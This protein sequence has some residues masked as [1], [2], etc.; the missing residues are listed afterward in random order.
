MGPNRHK[1]ESDLGQLT[2]IRHAVR[3]LC[4]QAWGSDTAD[5]VDELELAVTEA[6]TNVI[7]HAYEGQPGL[8]IEMV[9]EGD[10]HQVG[11]TLLHRGQGFDRRAIPPPSFD[12]SREGGFGLY[13]IEQSV[14]EV[15]YFRDERGWWGIRLVKQRS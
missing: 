14:D 4:R 1:F 10:A 11:V 2:A 8:P 12:G 7:R 9:L 6:A 13:L 5:A 15:D 3:A